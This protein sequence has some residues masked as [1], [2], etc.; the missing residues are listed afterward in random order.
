MYS[1]VRDD[2]RNFFT[3]QLE[4]DK[5]EAA[6]QRKFA[7]ARSGGFGGSQ[8]IDTQREYQNALDRGLLEVANR[9]DSASTGL[10]TADEQTRLGLID[11]IVSGV[12]L[13]SAMTSAISQLSTNADR[14]NQQATSDRMGNVFS[15]LVNSWNR[16]QFNQGGASARNRYS[17]QF[18][19][20]FPNE[21]TYGGTVSKGY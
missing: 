17:Q 21:S 1:T 5:A 16:D 3:R 12:D 10:R 8:A 2:T 11:R 9:A 18:G 4:Q 15:E 19:N 7:L 14:A 20:V 13:G 6:R